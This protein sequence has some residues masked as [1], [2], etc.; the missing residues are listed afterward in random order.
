[1]NVLTSNL[2]IKINFTIK[3]VWQLKKLLDEMSSLKQWSVCKEF[4]E[5]MECL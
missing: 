1:M 4:F 5:T 3:Y 2:C